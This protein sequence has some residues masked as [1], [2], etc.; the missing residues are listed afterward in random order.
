MTQHLKTKPE[1]NTKIIDDNHFKNS[2]SLSTTSNRYLQIS[3]AE[4][5]K[6]GKCN[7]PPQ[8]K[9]LDRYRMHTKKLHVYKPLSICK[10]QMGGG[11]GGWWCWVSENCPHIKILWSLLLLDL[12]YRSAVSVF[13]WNLPSRV[14]LEEPLPLPWSYD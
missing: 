13:T 4:A 6:H 12:S 8:L 14:Q 10:K 9:T 5:F 3:K 1:A 2:L 11:A 7:T